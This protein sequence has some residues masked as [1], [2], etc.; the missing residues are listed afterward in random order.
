METNKD[1]KIFI[2]V[3]NTVYALITAGLIGLGSICY[4]HIASLT[5]EQRV[6][7]LIDNKLN[8]VKLDTEEN[9]KDIDVI[10]TNFVKTISEINESMAEIRENLA[11]L[12]GQCQNVK[13]IPEPQA[14]I[15]EKK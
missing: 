12:R 13:A 10:E 14:V 9:K 3:K 7:E 2:T 4:E 15:K 6:N 8:P 11:F 5:N 1:K